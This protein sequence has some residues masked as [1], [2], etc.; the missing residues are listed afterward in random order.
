MTNV[1]MSLLI[2]PI[3]EENSWTRPVGGYGYHTCIESLGAQGRL[4][5]VARK[6]G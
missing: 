3:D 5:P 2:V 4:Q 1:M 6:G